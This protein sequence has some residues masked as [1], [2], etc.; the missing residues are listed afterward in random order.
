MVVGE[1]GGGDFVVGGSDFGGVVDV[2]LYCVE[3]FDEFVDCGVYVGGVGID[4]DG[5]VGFGIGGDGEVGD[6]V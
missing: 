3:F 2:L 1:D 4:C 5:L 6:V